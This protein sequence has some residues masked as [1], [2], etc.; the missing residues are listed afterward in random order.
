LYARDNDEKD[1]RPLKGLRGGGAS[2]ARSLFICKE[3]EIDKSEKFRN[4][5][6]IFEIDRAF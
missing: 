2:N 4:V 3:S 6:N 5:E 1:G